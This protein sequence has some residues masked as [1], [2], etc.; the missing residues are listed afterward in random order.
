MSKKT[1]EDM[2]ALTMR[3][4]R[5]TCVKLRRLNSCSLAICACISS[6][7]GS[8]VMPCKVLWRE[9]KACKYNRWCE[10]SRPVSHQPAWQCKQREARQ[11][12]LSAELFAGSVALY[13]TAARA[14]R[15]LTSDSS[16]KV[17]HFTSGW[18]SGSPPG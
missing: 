13:N 16:S 9:V 5:L 2:R 12:D 4:W 6:S 18:L 8:S 3:A 11:R 10:G 15:R 17:K 7:D 1:S 14:E